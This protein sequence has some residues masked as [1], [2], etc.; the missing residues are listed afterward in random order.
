MWC[1]DSVCAAPLLRNDTFLVADSCAD[2]QGQSLVA[3]ARG[4]EAL[5]GV[6]VNNNPSLQVAWEFTSCAPL[7]ESE[8]RRSARI[9]PG[10]PRCRSG[11]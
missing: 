8:R 3:S 5:S 11:G 1:V 10:V 4:M 9:G 6:D 7:V 2:C